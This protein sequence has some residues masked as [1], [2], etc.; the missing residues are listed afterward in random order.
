MDTACVSSCTII[1]CQVTVPSHSFFQAAPR[2]LSLLN[3]RCLL[4]R[5]FVQRQIFDTWYLILFPMLVNNLLLVTSALVEVREA[6]KLRVSWQINILQN[7]HWTSTIQL[8]TDS[9]LNHAAPHIQGY[10]VLL[11]EWTT[12]QTDTI[13][14]SSTGAGQ[15]GPQHLR[16]LMFRG[17]RWSVLLLAVIDQLSSASSC[18]IRFVA[19]RLVWHLDLHGIV[20]TC[21]LFRGSASTFRTTCPM[22]L[23]GRHSL[24]RLHVSTHVISSSLYSYWLTKSLSIM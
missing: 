8:V 21:V 17:L 4:S 3:S 1:R 20:L 13:V 2:F 11:K 22:H 14:S 5:W 24:L 18:V 6:W 23:A 19:G 16:G 9:D 10:T 12:K 7:P 15:C